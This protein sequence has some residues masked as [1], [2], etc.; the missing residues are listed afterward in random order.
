MLVLWGI[1][2]VVLDQLIKLAATTWLP[3][4]Q[5]VPIL[6]SLNL[7]LVHNTGVAFS[8]FAN[9]ALWGRLALIALG[10]VIIAYMAYWLYQLPR[11]KMVARFALVTIIAGAFGNVID[12]AVLGYVRDYV[13]FYIG[14]WHFAIFNFADMAITLGACCLIVDVL[15]SNADARRTEQTP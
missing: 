2:I 14:N 13:D 3:F 8:L 1:L 11:N 5:P 6:P 15:W 9:H 7:T 10:F 12:R 4:N